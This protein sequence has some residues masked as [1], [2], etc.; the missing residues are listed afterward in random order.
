MPL[1]PSWVVNLLPQASSAVR[2]SS[3]KGTGL[4]KGFLVLARYSGTH[5]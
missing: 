2:V 5:P 4:S 3:Y 1:W